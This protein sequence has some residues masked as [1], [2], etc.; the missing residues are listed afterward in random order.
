MGLVT[1]EENEDVDEEQR[2]DKDRKGN[3][4]VADVSRRVTVFA[5]FDE[6]GIMESNQLGIQTSKKDLSK[7]SR[8]FEEYLRPTEPSADTFNYNSV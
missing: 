7:T 5:E 3:K 2:D 1:Y 6:F 4:I 8:I